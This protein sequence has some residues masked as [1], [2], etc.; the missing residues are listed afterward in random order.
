MSQQTFRPLGVIVVLVGALAT[1]APAQAQ[2]LPLACTS[3]TDDPL[4]AG[5]TVKA[6]HVTE[7]RACVDALRVQVGLAVVTWTDLALE[8]GETWIR[9]VHVTE[10]RTALAAVYIAR[11]QTSPAYSDPTPTAQATV[12]REAHITEIRTAILVVAGVCTPDTC[13]NEGPIDEA[14]EY[15]HQDAV[16]SV[17]AVTDEVGAVVRTHDY[18]PFGE[19]V[20]AIDGYVQRYADQ[21]GDPESGSSYFGARY[22][23]AWTGRFT[24]VDPV[25]AGVGNPQRW[26]RYAYALNSPLTYVDPDGLYPCGIARFCLHTR[27][28]PNDDLM[29]DYTAP[30]TISVP[31]QPQEPAGR[32]G[33]DGTGGGGHPPGPGS[34][35]P[36]TP[37]PTPPSPTPTPVPSP[38]PVPQAPNP[39]PIADPENPEP[40]TTG[41]VDTPNNSTDWY[42]NSCVRSALAVGA[43]SVGIDSIGLIPAAG[44]ITRAIGNGAGYRGVVADQQGYKFVNALGKSTSAAQGLSG[45]VH[46]SPLGLLSSGLTAAGF[47]PGLG[48]LASGASI[49]V[50]VVKTGLAI[51]QC[52]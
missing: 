23:R 8:A 10:L 39:S 51:S 19:G 37:N 38:T 40:G 16:G 13:T 9:A 14:I 25:F 7:L 49:V 31:E 32:R 47:V 12:V 21:E 5:V 35:D 42:E 18:F 22:Y 24:T 26:N 48:Q 3:F 41:P 17:R 30:T 4:Q 27:A 29:E 52:P 44:G 11:G 2:T 20:S 50:D 1:A 45:V 34:P 28:T 6:Q 33:R 46:T 36:Q 43:L 15:Y